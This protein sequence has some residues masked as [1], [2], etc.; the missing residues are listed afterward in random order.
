M[1]YR[2]VIY[3]QIHDPKFIGCVHIHTR[4]IHL[5]AY[6]SRGE[7]MKRLLK[8]PF[9]TEFCG[10][11]FPRNHK[12]FDVLNY[13]THQLFEAG[14]TNYQANYNQQLLNPNLYREPIVFTKEYLHRIYG[15]L[16]PEGPQILTMENLEAGF[17]IWLV[18][19][20][21]A[22]AAF[23]AEWLVRLKDFAVTW[24]ILSAFYI[25]K[26]HNETMRK[27]LVRVKSIKSQELNELEKT[28]HEESTIDLIDEA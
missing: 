26:S 3:D 13:N 25:N 28:L 16:Y 2:D 22:I 20:S 4:Y 10:M 5:L 9:I 8:E 11:E 18:C 19:V 6:R 24:F 23:A 7:I 12:L 17:A 21:F 1:E 15:K 14:I 27:K